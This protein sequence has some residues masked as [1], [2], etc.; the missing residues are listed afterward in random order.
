MYQFPEEMKTT[1][2]TVR[3]PLSITRI[4]MGKLSPSLLQTVFAEIPALTGTGCWIG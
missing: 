4:S 2:E 1:F 3:F